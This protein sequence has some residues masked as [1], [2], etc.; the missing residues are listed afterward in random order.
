M[1]NGT[2]ILAFAE[3]RLGNIRRASLETVTAARQVADQTGG[4]HGRGHVVDT[5]HRGAVGHRPHGGG[6]R[7]FEA[8]LD[9]GA[10]GEGAEEA[11]AAG[12]DQERRTEGGEVAQAVQERQ[13]VGGGLAEA[14]ARV[15]WRAP[16]FRCS[17]E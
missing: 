12:P 11:L 2:N 13:V 6:Q 3:S 16:R 7:A 1:S 9:G 4:L 5:D 8:V 17:P 10:A 15:A 14:D